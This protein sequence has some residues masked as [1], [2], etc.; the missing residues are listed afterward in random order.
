MTLNK[1]ASISGYHINF[2]NQYK[3]K[4]TRSMFKE[5]K[6]EHIL[7]LMFAKFRDEVKFL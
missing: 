3:K 2:S 5:F 7:L 4:Q 6:K 1:E